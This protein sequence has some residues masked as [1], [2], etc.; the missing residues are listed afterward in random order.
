MLTT[1]SGFSRL[2]PHVGNELSSVRC[3]DLDNLNLS[4][5]LAAVSLTM[6]RI[7]PKKLFV[8]LFTMELYPPYRLFSFP[9]F[10]SSIC[11]LSINQIRV[12]RLTD[13]IF[14]MSRI[15]Q[16][17]NHASIYQGKENEDFTNYHLKSVNVSSL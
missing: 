9:A 1:N 8:I 6:N 10:F 12:D 4:K 5:Q 13:L 15:V 7:T 17:Q 3:C 14:V 16:V 11:S 2:L